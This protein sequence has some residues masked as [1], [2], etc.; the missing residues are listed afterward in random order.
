MTREV[1]HQKSFEKALYAITD[2][3]PSGKLLGIG[4]FADMYVNTSQV[5]AT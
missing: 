5:T 1:A 2:N 4:P 3:F